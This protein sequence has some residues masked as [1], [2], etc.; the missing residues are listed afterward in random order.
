MRRC[1]ANSWEMRSLRGVVVFCVLAVT[2]CSSGGGPSVAA[3]TSVPAT[4]S[5]V[6]ATLPPAPS[7]TVAVDP[8]AVPAVI[9]L[10]YLDRVMVELNRIQGDAF[11][12]VVATK[13]VPPEALAQMQATATGTSLSTALEQFSI[14]IVNRFKGARIPPGNLIISAKR[15]LEQSDLCIAFEATGDFSA[16][17]DHPV[18]KSV[19]YTLKRRPVGASL[20]INITPWVIQFDGF[21]FGGPPCEA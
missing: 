1:V 2:A 8:F 9:D 20:E 19:V 14:Q 15:V 3:P 12:T 7:T 16:V 11:R 4:S 6:A 10:A 17:A 5:T 18:V 13:T 21:D